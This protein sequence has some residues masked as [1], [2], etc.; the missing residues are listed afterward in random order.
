MPPLDRAA[1]RRLTRPALVLAVVATGLV[2]AGAR[3]SAPAAGAT[4]AV[5]AVAIA[6]TPDGAGYWV[7]SST[8]GVF[9]FGDARFHGSAS[10]VFLGAPVVGMAATPSGNG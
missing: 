8:G 6:R 4:P 10:G 5:S 7:A 9:A 1:P 2:W 3:A